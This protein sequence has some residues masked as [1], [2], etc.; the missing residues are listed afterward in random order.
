MQTEHL[1]LLALLLAAGMLFYRYVWWRIGRELDERALLAHDP[2]ARQKKLEELERL[3]ASNPADEQTLLLKSTLLFFD[4]NFSA[5]ADTLEE[6][7]RLR[8]EDWEGWAELAECRMRKG[9]GEAALQAAR[10]SL[11]ANAG[12]CDYLCLCLRARLLVGDY[13]GARKD[14]QDWKVQDRQRV[15]HPI[16]PHRWSQQYQMPKPEIVEDPAV[17]LYEAALLYR[18]GECARAKSIL[19][20]LE[21]DNPEYLTETIA[22]DPLLSMF[23]QETE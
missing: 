18:E 21:N 20:E 2:Q 3:L 11:D 22:E 6:Y 5:S 14:L 19:S 16:V 4:K 17:R 12:N 8:P 23:A 7:L 10:K 13:T 15:E 9:E 1:I